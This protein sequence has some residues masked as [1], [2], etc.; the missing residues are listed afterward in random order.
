MLTKR[1]G[2]VSKTL[3]QPPKQQYSNAHCSRDENGCAAS[4]SQD[5]MHL[6]RW[7]IPE[8]NRLRD[9]A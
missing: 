1:L 5:V 9:R 2:K 8:V 3:A 7:G 4:V 6:F